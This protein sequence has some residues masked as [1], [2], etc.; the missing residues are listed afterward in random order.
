M[1]LAI[2]RACETGATIDSVIN[3][4]NGMVVESIFSSPPSSSSSVESNS[5]FSALL[6]NQSPVA[7][8]SG[9]VGLL[10]VPCPEIVLSYETN[11]S[12][13]TSGAGNGNNRSGSNNAGGNAS[14]AAAPAAPA[15][16]MNPDLCRLYLV[17]VSTHVDAILELWNLGILDSRRFDELMKAIRCAASVCANFKRS[18]V[19]SSG[20]L[21]ALSK[22]AKGYCRKSLLARNRSLEAKNNSTSNMMMEVEESKMSNKDDFEQ[23]QQA[24]SSD[25]LT[26]AH[27]E[28]LQC[29]LLASQYNFARA[30]TAEN[31][32][33]TISTS[34]SNNFL[35][36]SESYL[37]YH[38]F[39][40]LIHLG[41]DD[42]TS[43]I[44]AFET[45][46]TVPSKIVSCVTIE[47]R[48]K[49]LLAECLRLQH[50]DEEFYYDCG[51]PQQQ[52]VSESSIA[53]DSHAAHPQLIK[54]ILDVPNAV[55]SC[56][57][58][59]FTS[60]STS[61]NTASSG[62]GGTNVPTS[63]SQS[64]TPPPKTIQIYESIVKSFLSLDVK[65]F[66]TIINN[67]EE[68]LIADGNLGLVKQLFPLMQYRILKKISNVYEAI[69]LAN[70]A[71]KLGISGGGDSGSDDPNGIK[72]V[73]SFLL[74]TALRQKA[75]Q[76]S[77]LYS[78]LLES[79]IDFTIDS[80]SSVV[81]FDE[82]GFENN[83]HGDDNG[84]TIDRNER[85]DLQAE[86]SKRIALSMD[87]AKRIT[88]MDI[89]AVSSAKY[90]AILARE[91]PEESADK[92]G[93]GV[94]GKG[95]VSQSVII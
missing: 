47:A 67:E 12:T 93:D 35:L 54:R 76:E 28:F 69:P 86:L 10:L 38:Y 6:S 91:N 51:G 24:M 1:R 68:Q 82:V 34:K 23:Q 73:E 16:G 61:T 85:E 46:L 33:R 41:C 58:R 31:P 53:Q 22:L 11:S 5:Y 25:I 65:S 27:V 84:G 14:A 29:C 74:Q 63:T 81:Y 79:Y 94:K 49:M 56:V 36:S 8:K 59:Y 75:H 80:E 20:I 32:I 37:R 50:D 30:F 4:T 9:L 26:P 48:K 87:L 19:S 64:Q 2:R 42:Y 40:G 18:T 66:T 95:G 90:Q 21:Y 92:S 45:C 7:N 83:V 60:A 3:S 71:K 72:A 55:S 44:S 15:V 70:L 57:H 78:P 43:A 52:R 39:L 17:A 89:A 77:D 88:K 13:S 62:S